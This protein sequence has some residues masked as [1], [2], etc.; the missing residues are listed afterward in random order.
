MR[1]IAIPALCLLAACSTGTTAKVQST[2]AGSLATAQADL[3]KAVTFYGVAKG[4]ALAAE[5]AEPSIKPVVDEALAVLDPLSATAQQ[6]LA[7]T[8]TDAAPVE[9][10]A[11]EI[12]AQAVALANTAAPAVK[13]VG[14]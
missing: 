8:Q 12:Q 11:V 14:G 10:L 9:A 7:T 3:G 1:I 6:L 5:L 4:I 2:V 13:V